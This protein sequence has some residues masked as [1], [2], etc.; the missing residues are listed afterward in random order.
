MRSLSHEGKYEV[1]TV[2]AYAIVREWLDENHYCD[3][4]IKLDPVRSFFI[5]VI[6]RLSFQE[7]EEVRKAARHNVHRDLLARTQVIS[8]LEELWDNY[9]GGDQ[10]S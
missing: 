3:A 5:A 6:R 8:G 4:I 9:C 10:C 1:V 7:L 2:C